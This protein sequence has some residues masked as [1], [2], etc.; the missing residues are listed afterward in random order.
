MATHRPSDDIH[1]Y[2]VCCVKDCGYDAEEEYSI[3][4]PD[5]QVFY[6]SACAAHV[7]VVY[8]ELCDALSGRKKPENVKGLALDTLFV[9]D[10][11]NA[12]MKVKYLIQQGLSSVVPPVPEEEVSEPTAKVKH[13]FSA[14]EWV[15]D[16]EYW[17]NAKGHTVPLRTIP[18][19][20]LIC[21]ILCIVQANYARIPKWLS[22]T[23]GLLK[24]EVPVVYPTG[25]LEADSADLR[26]KL[27]EFED[28]V[29]A[30]GLI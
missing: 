27:E 16:D 19:D 10:P 20:E 9:Q 25:A 1:K 8:G 29:D 3:T 11:E 5:K 13:S 6:L 26:L 15:H 12:K 30:R 28:E 18:N 24:P 4:R 17:M 14:W 2:Q 21:S 22:W 7:D 23:K